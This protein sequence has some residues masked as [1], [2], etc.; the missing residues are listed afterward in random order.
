MK[1]KKTDKIQKN[2]NKQIPFY[3]S[4][5]WFHLMIPFNDGLV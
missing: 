5:Q 2:E 1:K 3:D 4:N